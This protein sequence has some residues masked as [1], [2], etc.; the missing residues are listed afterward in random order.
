MSAKQ[1]KLVVI[2]GCSGINGG[3]L[4]SHFLKPEHSECHWE[5]IGLATS[6]PKHMPWYGSSQVKLVEVNLL[7]ENDSREK[8]AKNPDI[9]RATHLFFAAYKEEQDP[10]EAIKVNLTMLKNCV[11]NVSSVAKG[12]EKVVLYTGSKYYGVDRGPYK[13]PASEDDP[14]LNAPI[15]YYQQEDFLAKSQKGKQWSYN[16]VRPNEVI[17]YSKGFMNQGVTL[18]IYAVLCKE[19][20]EKFKFPGTVKSWEVLSDASDAKLICRLIEWLCFHDNPN[21][22]FNIVNG[23]LY[24]WKYLWPK[25]AEYFELEYEAPKEGEHLRLTEWFK[26]KREDWKNIVEKYNLKAPPELE[27]ISTPGFVQTW[28]GKEYDAIHDMNKAR[29]AGFTGYQNTVKSY[30]NLWNQLQ[31]MKIIPKARR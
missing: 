16:V 10:H 30:Y 20:G 8:L 21:Q 25:L 26:D 15:F 17:G 1:N 7:D 18:A 29:E 12:L 28:V 2:A 22:A 24:R 4:V 13:T 6:P 5:I 23:D 11:E 19:L 31:D 14:R 3:S 27:K 9:A